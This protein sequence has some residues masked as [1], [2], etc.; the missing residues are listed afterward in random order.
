MTEITLEKVQI[1]NVAGEKIA[2]VEL[3]LKYHEG[4]ITAKYD[5]MDRQ[6]ITE[7]TGLYVIVVPIGF[8]P[9]CHTCW[10]KMTGWWT[11][12]DQRV[13]VCHECHTEYYPD[14]NEWVKKNRRR[15]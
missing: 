8:T 15:D 10:H 14:N 6:V 9:V 11:E 2:E 12:Y 7:L 13:Y 1:V 3:E 5:H 4:H